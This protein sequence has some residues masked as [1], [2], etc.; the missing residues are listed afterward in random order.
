MNNSILKCANSLFNK[1]KF[2]SALSLY[3]LF[4]ANNQEISNLINVNLYIARNKY[5]NSFQ[6]GDQKVFVRI[7]RNMSHFFDQDNIVSVINFAKNDLGITIINESDEYSEYLLILKKFELVDKKIWDYD[8]D[9]AVCIVEQEICKLISVF[10]SSMA[11]DKSC[12]DVGID[13]ILCF[14][15]DL[16][17]LYFDMQKYEKILYNGVELNL[18]LRRNREININYSVIIPA[19][20]AERTLSRAI[21]SCFSQNVD[22]EVIL[23]NDGSSDMTE[24]LIQY[25]Y[26]KYDSITFI[27]CKNNLGQGFGRNVAL[28]YA[29]GRYVTF[30]DGDDFYSDIHY[31]K[32]I[33]VE[34]INNSYPDVIVSP[35]FRCINSSL[36]KD[37]ILLGSFDGIGAVQAFINR[38]FGT[39]GPGGKFFKMSMLS[40]DIRFVEYGYSQDVLFSFGALMSANTIISVDIAGYVYDYVDNSS[41]RPVKLTSRHFYSSLRLLLEVH[42]KKF[43]L[44]NLGIDISLDKFLKTWKKDHVPRLKSYL[45]NL[46]DLDSFVPKIL[47]Q[48]GGFVNFIPLDSCKNSIISDMYKIQSSKLDGDDFCNEMFVRHLEKICTNI[49]FQIKRHVLNYS[50][51]IVVIYVSHLS[52]GGLEK[53]ATQ[54]GSILA[55]EFDVIY[56]V[57]NINKIHYEYD[58]CVFK[59][60]LSSIN[61]LSILENAIFIFDFKYKLVSEDFPACNYMIRNYFY[62][63]ICTIHNT[64]TCHCY[65]DKIKNYIGNIDCNEIF[66]IIC[67]S[68][69]VRNKFVSNYGE[70]RNISVLHNPV[71]LKKID[72]ESNNIDIANKFILFVGRLNATKH[73][74]IDLLVE[75]FAKSK[76]IETHKLILAGDGCLDRDILNFIVD[77]GMEDKIINIGFQK[78][79]YSYMKKADFVFQ[80]SRWEGFS[81]ALIE[82]L[83]CG[84]P[85]LS[86]V[87][88]GASEVI[89]HKVNGYLFEIECIDQMIS[90]VDY[91]IDNASFM[92]S[93]CKS[94]VEKFSFENYKK[95]LFKI[96]QS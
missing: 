44:Y 23:F 27:N 9:K 35:Y 69:A 24:D 84:T 65:F 54:L 4:A 6:H 41:W 74:G 22:L 57:D 94:S 29:A 34:I 79:I 51:P 52:T 1:G 43:Q 87:A 3:K 13:D 88:G 75:A 26:C 93:V 59:M 70:L 89:I 58:G 16:D 91:M 48:L 72:S 32:K 15:S 80:P 36:R 62:K 25:Y 20:N 12:L 45:D 63:Y 90:G 60:D 33:E 47:K 31:F 30:L 68:N 28:K 10:R 2:Y 38:D 67:V 55:C 77:N 46:D 78:D 66:S 86:S 5:E 85:V 96:L 40:D 18:L 19:F 95:E 56:L 11:K 83:A 53:V 92:R 50:K 14:G 64:E 82:S 37:S 8:T 39:H 81:L 7:N 71:D 73:K 61:V 42:L 17:I 49:T 21:E 76:G